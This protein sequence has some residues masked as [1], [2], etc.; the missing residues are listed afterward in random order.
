[1]SNATLTDVEKDEK[2]ARINRSIQRIDSFLSNHGNPYKL[3]L[4]LYLA[5]PSACRTCYLERPSFPIFE[6]EYGAVDW[7]KDFPYLRKDQTVN[8][9]MMIDLLMKGNATYFPAHWTDDMLY[10][11]VKDCVDNSIHEFEYVF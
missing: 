4:M 3:R 9:V 10:L 5:T 1:M 7:K 11:F 6:T 8:L 2:F